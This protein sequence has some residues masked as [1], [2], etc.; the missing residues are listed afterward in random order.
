MS[1]KGAYHP[2]KEP[3]PPYKRPAVPL[4]TTHGFTFARCPCGREFMDAASFQEHAVYC[5]LPYKP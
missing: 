4:A 3:H 5:A 1:P 2:P